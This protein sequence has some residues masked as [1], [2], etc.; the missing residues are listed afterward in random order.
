VLRLLSDLPQ[1]RALQEAARRLVEQ[2][3]DWALI[4][5]QQD[6]VYTLAL[7]KHERH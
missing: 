4:G 6:R 2:R 7:R 1:R 5:Q 3:Y